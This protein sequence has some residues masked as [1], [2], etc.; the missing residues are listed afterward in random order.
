MST[1]EIYVHHFREDLCDDSLNAFS[2][3]G[4]NQFQNEIFD[5]VQELLKIRKEYP[6]LQSGKLLHFY[7]FDD[8]YIYFRILDDQKIMIVVNNKDEERSIDFNHVRHLVTEENELINLKSGEKI[9]FQCG[10]A[11]KIRAKSTELFLVE[12]Q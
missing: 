8:Q 7:P 10:D 12:S 1:T 3:E 6:A 2:K 9:K 5:Y 11:L 4:R